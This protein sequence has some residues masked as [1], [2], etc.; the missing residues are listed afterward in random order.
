MAAQLSAGGPGVNPLLPFGAFI[1]ERRRAVELN[2]FSAAEFVDRPEDVV[3]PHTHGDAHFWFVL[4]GFYI[5]T[6]AGLDGMCAPPTVIFNPAGTTHFD[7][8]HTRGGAFLTLSLGDALVAR[9]GGHGA[10]SERPVGFPS[11][12]LPWLGTRLHRELMQADSLTPL[13]AEGLALELLA[14][15]S[16]EHARRT[17]TRAS[18]LEAAFQLVQ[19]CYLDKLTVQDMARAVGVHPLLLGRSFRKAYGCSPG[20]MVRRR[21]VARAEELLRRGGMP[22]A[23]VALACGFSDQAQLTKAFRRITGLTPGR[24]RALLPD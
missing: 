13:V 22:L 20:E 16:R 19:D 21:R 10:L 14:H 18:W 9:V 5:S 12:E 7:R 1:G 8:F 24:Y 15:A 4:R 23:E 17:W 2:G 6:A 3:S 11:G